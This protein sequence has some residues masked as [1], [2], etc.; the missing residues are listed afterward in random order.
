MSAFDKGSPVLIEVEFQRQTA[1]SSTLTYFDPTGATL[2][3]TDQLGAVMTSTT[4]MTKSST[5][6]Y[7][8]ICQTATTWAGGPYHTTV[9]CT[10]G[11]N[12]DVD[13]Q[14]GAFELE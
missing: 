14:M 1:F 9:Q 7:Y 3:V 10:D 6:K 5:G 2:S 13:V 8:F 12:S 11:T 4:N